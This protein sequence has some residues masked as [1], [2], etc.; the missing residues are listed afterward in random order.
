ML[1]VCFDQIQESGD[2]LCQ[3]HALVIN[4]AFFVFFHFC[5]FQLEFARLLSVGATETAIDE[6]D[7]RRKLP[8]ILESVQAKNVIDANNVTDRQTD[9]CSGG[10][11]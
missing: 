2:L 8:E 9:P 4:F 7:S 5:F 1:E 11:L 6:N 10:V 3:H